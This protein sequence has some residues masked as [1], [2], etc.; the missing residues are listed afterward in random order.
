MSPMDCATRASSGTCIAGTRSTSPHR[1]SSTRA[2]RTFLA[3]QSF[4]VP[5]W[6]LTSLQKLHLPV[7]AARRS[8]ADLWRFCGLVTM[9]GGDTMSPASAAAPACDG[10]KVEASR[11]KASATSAC[12]HNPC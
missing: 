6:R 5:E 10:A 3:G 1:R 11:A 9:A 12:Q 4:H 2:P 8:I 7:G